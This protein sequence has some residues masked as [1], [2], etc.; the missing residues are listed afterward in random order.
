LTRRRFIEIS[1]DASRL[2][3]T[4]EKH[5]FKSLGQPN[6]Q[7]EGYAEKSERPNWFE[8]KRDKGDKDVE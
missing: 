1:A 7:R 6:G 8:I 2:K 5:F 4:T 3:S